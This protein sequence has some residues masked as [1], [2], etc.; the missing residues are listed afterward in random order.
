M[1]IFDGLPRLSPEEKIPISDLNVQ[2]HEVCSQFTNEYLQKIKAE[3]AKDAELIVLRNI[4]CGGRP[5]T[6]KKVPIII[7]PRW[8]FRAQIA[9]EDSAFSNASE[10]FSS[11]VS[12]FA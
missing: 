1:P 4:G 3:T 8:T 7:R 11:Y 6:I 9:I 12:T 5:T 10:L 2:V